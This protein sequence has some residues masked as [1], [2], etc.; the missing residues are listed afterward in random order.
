MLKVTKEHQH[1]QQTIGN[2][3]MKK[4][5]KKGFNKINGNTPLTNN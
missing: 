3:S 4:M 1:Y 2:H 5:Y